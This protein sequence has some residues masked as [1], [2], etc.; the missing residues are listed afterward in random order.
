MRSGGG[1]SGGGGGGGGS[2]RQMEYRPQLSLGACGRF[3]AAES[4]ARAAFILRV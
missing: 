2:R 1:S 3:Y 4:N